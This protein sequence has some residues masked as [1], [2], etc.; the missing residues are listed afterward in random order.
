MRDEVLLSPELLL[1]AYEIGIF[2]MSEARHSATLFWVDPEKRGVMPLDGFHISRS[3]KRALR[4]RD[5]E[6]RINTAFEAVVEG[7]ADREETWI[8][9]ELRL[10]YSELYLRGYAHSMEIWDDQGLRGGVFGVALGGAFFG[11][12][13]FSARTDG[14]KLAMVYLVDRLRRSGFSLFDTQF[15]TDH[16]TSLGAQEISRAE[17]RT[18]LNIALK[19]NADFRS[20]PAHGSAQ[21]VLQRNTQT[22]NRG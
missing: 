15:T 17:Y 8:N 7:C 12:S 6:V 5:Y 14:S 2:P 1:R 11:E 18:L 22:S 9:E 19:K 4:R 13:M 20:A 16:L 21:D 10:L 3:L